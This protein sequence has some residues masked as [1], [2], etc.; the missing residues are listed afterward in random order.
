MK[1]IWYISKYVKTSFVGISGSRGFHLLEELSN[2]GFNCSI[3]S[4]YPFKNS[5]KFDKEIINL[6]KNFKYIYINSYKYRCA[7]SFKRIL[8][9]IDFEI[10]LFFFNKKSL[11]RPDLIIVSS[12]SL[13]TILNG[14]FLKWKYSCK[15]IFEVRDIWPLTLTEEGGF[16][17][18]NIFIKLLGFIE[19]LGYKYSDH[20][21]GTMP[22]LNEHVEKRLGYSKKVTCIPIGY[23]K[24]EIRKSKEI[25]SRIKKIIP[26]NKFIVGYFGSIGIT[27]ALD[28]FFNVICQSQKLNDIHFLV[29][30]SGDLK[31]KYYLK[32]KGLKNITMLPLIDKKY[33]QSLFEKCDLLYFSTYNSEIWRYGQSLNKLVEYMLSGKPIVGSYNGYESMIN[34]SFCGE[35]IKPYNEKVILKAILKYKNMNPTERK[36]IGFRGKKWIIKNRSYKKLS[37]NLAD[38]IYRII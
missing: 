14:L 35:F 5:R 36:K 13:L 30:G 17:K 25:P 24:E 12:L 9:W 33:I 7:N 8:S 26:N 29:A 34:E 1:N 3:F 23:Q 10:K 20:I 6:K 32:T 18:E 38:L 4:S 22:N 19:Y 11:L 2:Y 15:L 28:P 31:Q 21:I 16:K 27:N 37:K